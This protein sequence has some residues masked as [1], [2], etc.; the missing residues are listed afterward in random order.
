MNDTN[1][2]HGDESIVSTSTA[3]ESE[4]S[5]NDVEME[6]A[7]LLKALSAPY[8]REELRPTSPILPSHQ[9]HRFAIDDPL[10]GGNE[11]TSTEKV[12]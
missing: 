8:N 3:G 1:D 4:D 9:Y 6:N 11:V 7:R 2:V 12:S 5:I 10:P